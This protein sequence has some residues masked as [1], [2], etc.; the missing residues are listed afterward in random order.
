MSRRRGHYDSI[1][2]EE[3]NNVI[4]ESGHKKYS[5]D[6]ISARSD[7]REIPAGKS[8][9]E[10]SASSVEEIV[11]S[12][13]LKSSDQP[14]YRIDAVI[15][16]GNLTDLYGPR[17]LT[18]RYFKINKTLEDIIKRTSPEDHTPHT[19][20]RSLHYAYYG[21]LVSAIRSCTSISSA[22][23]AHN[24]STSVTIPL[25]AI[26]VTK[27]EEETAYD[28]QS[29]SSYFQ[30]Y[31]G[32]G[33]TVWFS[34]SVARAM[35]EDEK[36]SS[37]PRCK[38]SVRLSNGR[39]VDGYRMS[40]D[41]NV[42]PVETRFGD[43]FLYDNLHYICYFRTSDVSSLNDILV[44]RFKARCHVVSDSGER[45]LFAI[46][47]NS[48]EVFSSISNA[49]SIVRSVVIGCGND[50]HFD[51][52]HSRLVGRTVEKVRALSSFILTGAKGLVT[53]EA[54]ERP[55]LV[56]DNV[57]QKYQFFTMDLVSLFPHEVFYGIA[58][59]GEDVE[60][61]SV[62]SA[63][64]PPALRMTDADPDLRSELEQTRS[65]I[66]DL[67]AHF[68]EKCDLIISMISRISDGHAVE[69][70]NDIVTTLTSGALSRQ[71]G[72]HK[73]TDSLPPSLEGVKIIADGREIEDSTQK[74]L[75]TTTVDLRQ[76]TENEIETPPGQ[77]IADA[78]PDTDWEEVKGSHAERSDPLS[79][80]PER[81]HVT[82]SDRFSRLEIE[83]SDKYAALVREEDVTVASGEASSFPNR[84][85]SEDSIAVETYNSIM[86]GK[87]TDTQ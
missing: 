23:R 55:N 22:V 14:R 40:G 1:V 24:G 38:L 35:D 42:A 18:S 4:R 32:N 83:E 43:V 58:T 39:V 31:P 19:E 20:E 79:I 17:Y 2:N 25:K 29:H 77:Q 86:A 11:S 50:I 68:N 76:Q 45:A 62:P 12:Y 72:S 57:R 3:I 15:N 7:D 44:S 16:L 37:L 63:L 48:K 34:E 51:S 13:P 26:V 33:C 56:G 9:H 54:F 85:R 59:A 46:F 41:E 67:S 64:K 71:E 61:F 27:N 30:S 5:I 21:S 84:E 28:L 87:G 8:V 53:S 6:N 66:A 74:D 47:E 80:R 52:R 10:C 60:K 69:G 82:I 81:P 65:Q 75:I 49:Q 36:C 73:N 70:D 78:N